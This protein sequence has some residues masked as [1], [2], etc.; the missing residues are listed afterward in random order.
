MTVRP[1]TPSR[2]SPADLAARTLGRED[3]LAS[4]GRRLDS[5]AR[6]G[7]RPHTLLVGP[8]GSGKTHVI[9]VVLHRL[10]GE[11]FVVARLDED[12]VGV[13]SYADLLAELARSAGVEVGTGGRDAAALE[14]AL[15]GHLD[16]RVLLAVIEN[17]ARVFAGMGT[18][19]QRDLRSFVETTGAVVLLAS[20]PQLFAG[21]GSRNEPWF[22][23]FA[24][25]RLDPL[26]PPQCVDLLGH[27]AGADVV[28]FVRSRGGRARVAALH[29]LVGGWPR[30]WMV[31][32]GHAD[33]EALDELV[34]AV[35]QL[36][37]Q[38]VPSFQQRLWS[39]PP[40]EARLVRALGTGPPAATV[41]ELAAA[42]GLTER[43]AATALGRLADGGWVRGE[44]RPGAD[45]RRTW[46]RL[47][48]PLLRLHFQY[49]GGGALRETV[50][51]VRAW[52]DPLLPLPPSPPAAAGEPEAA[53]EALIGR[54]RPSLM[55]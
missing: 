31:V 41:A 13:A 5:A 46:Y 26:T 27:V 11:G 24:V 19:G 18:G 1:F 49:R 23:S 28:R 54:P 52:F 2:D 32:A 4:I 37:E 33:P 22:G 51:Y 25:E 45:Q 12:A 21:I 53:V 55:S 36:V 3:L 40:N 16:G 15:V 38:F 35:E 8:R 39:L 43:T 6:T 47:R 44:K 30:V 7:N 48:E 50:D 42:A 20:T 14:A 10:A 9:A 29:H 17:L 34:P